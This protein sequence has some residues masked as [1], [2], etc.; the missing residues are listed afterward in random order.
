MG[1]GDVN[2]SAVIGLLLGWPAILAGL[3]LAILLGGA[4]SLVYL[5][6]KLITRRYEAFSAIPYGPFLVA[7]TVILLY[8]R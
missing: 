6:Y 4:V 7:S 3:I 8:F 5:M 2:L 1:F